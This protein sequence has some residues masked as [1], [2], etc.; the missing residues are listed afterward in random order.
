MNKVMFVGVSTSWE[1]QKISRYETHEM[2]NVNR[3]R[4]N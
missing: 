3:P 1:Q 4:L 2:T